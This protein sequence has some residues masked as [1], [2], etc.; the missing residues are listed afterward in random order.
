L[1]SIVVGLN[2]EMAGISPGGA[3]LGMSAAFAVGGISAGLLLLTAWILHAR[4]GRRAA[5]VIVLALAGLTVWAPA[6]VS[7]ASGSTLFAQSFANNTINTAYPVSLPTSPSGANYACLT[8]SGNSSTAP[9]LSCTSNSDPQGSGKL[10][11]TAAS[12]GQTGGV[13]ASTS[14]PTSQGIDATFNWLQ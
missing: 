3:V 13:F 8:A 2:V 7:A 9:L 1:S 5:L 14:V 4:S 10:R 11:L 6:Q 12:Y